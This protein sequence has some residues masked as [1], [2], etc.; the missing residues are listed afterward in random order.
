MKTPVKKL[1][2]I[3]ESYPPNITAFALYNACSQLIMVSERYEHLRKNVNKN[4]VNM[5]AELLSESETFFTLSK[6]QAEGKQDQ[7]ETPE[8]AEEEKTS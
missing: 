1:I 8:T 3:T 7:E 2:A 5:A 6:Q 4:A